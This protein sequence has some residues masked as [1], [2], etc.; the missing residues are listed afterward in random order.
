MNPDCSFLFHSPE[1]YNKLLDIME[2]N[3][4]YHYRKTVRYDSNFSLSNHLKA[5]QTLLYLFNDV[6]F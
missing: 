3:F 5:R 2:S 4:S 1:V 6:T